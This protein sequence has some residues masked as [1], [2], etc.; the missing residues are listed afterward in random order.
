MPV[1]VDAKHT[2]SVLALLTKNC[3]FLSDTDTLVPLVFPFSFTETF[4]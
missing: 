4:H 3:I 1:H 2:F